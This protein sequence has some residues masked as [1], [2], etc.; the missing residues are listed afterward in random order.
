MSYRKK[1]L[2]HR[3]ELYY[4]ICIF[5][6]LAVLLFSFFGPSGYREMRRARLELEAQRTRVDQLKH[7]NS[8]RMKN[9]EALR[10]DEATLERYAREKGYGREGEIIQQ[11]PE[12]SVQE[13]EEAKQ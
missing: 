7:S 2:S 4:I 10:S 9:I 5:A 11:V 12:L 6:L 13:S 8:E 1:R 3:R